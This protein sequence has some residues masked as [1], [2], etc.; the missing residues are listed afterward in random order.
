[1]HLDALNEAAMHVEPIVWLA[2]SHMTDCALR[3]FLGV[4][5]LTNIVFGFSFV[6]G[7]IMGAVYVFFKTLFRVIVSEWLP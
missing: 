3:F 2:I 7:L 6:S 5:D 4:N 1:M